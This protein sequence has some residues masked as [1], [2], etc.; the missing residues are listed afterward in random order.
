MLYTCTRYLSFPKN[1]HWQKSGHLESHLAYVIADLQFAY[2]TG[3][4][5]VA[6]L[7][8]HYKID[9]NIQ[10]FQSAQV[11]QTLLKWI[12]V[13]VLTVLLI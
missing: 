11:L 9:P 12:P 7:K 10:V 1:E 5:H 3:H 6:T 8:L 13:C 4:L 2:Q